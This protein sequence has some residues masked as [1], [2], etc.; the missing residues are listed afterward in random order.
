MGA[1][2]LMNALATRDCDSGPASDDAKLA[3]ECRQPLREPRLELSVRAVL[4][5][6]IDRGP[7]RLA[8]NLP[9]QRSKEAQAANYADIA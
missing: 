6:K 2:S 9:M 5:L 4:E 7:R 1:P 8:L 3:R